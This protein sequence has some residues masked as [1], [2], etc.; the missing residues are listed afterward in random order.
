MS[1][2]FSLETSGTTKIRKRLKKFKSDTFGGT[3]T[4]NA[5]CSAENSD[6]SD[7]HRHKNAKNTNKQ[8]LNEIDFSAYF[9]LSTKPIEETT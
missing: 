6:L 1:K 5:S 9:K 3:F 2:Q 4:F 8:R 7:G